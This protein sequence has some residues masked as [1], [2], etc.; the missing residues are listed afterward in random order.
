MNVQHL[1]I[2]SVPDLI[3][4]LGGLVFDDEVSGTAQQWMKGSRHPVQPRGVGS[5]AAGNFGEA[6]V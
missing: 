2:F 5:E 1:A 6:E 4:G 3:A